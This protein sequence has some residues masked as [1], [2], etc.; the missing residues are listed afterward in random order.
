MKYICIANF[1]KLSHDRKYKIGDEIE[2]TK[3][4]GDELCDSGHVKKTKAVRKPKTK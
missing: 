1:H 2:L 4:E 3:K